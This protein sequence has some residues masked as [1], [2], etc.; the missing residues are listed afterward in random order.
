MAPMFC[1]YGN[2][3]NITNVPEY[4]RVSH[5]NELLVR[6]YYSEDGYVEGCSMEYSPW[7]CS[8]PI[9]CHTRSVLDTTKL[10]N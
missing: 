3:N 8:R 5:S 7:K 2:S 4:Y 9:K 10:R 6:S 1:F